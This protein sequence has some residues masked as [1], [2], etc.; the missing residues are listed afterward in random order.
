[1]LSYFK[2]SRFFLYII[3]FGVAI[4]S[5]STLFPF[6]VGKYVWFR[7]L[8]AIA[9]ILFLL[10]LLFDQQKRIYWERFKK[11]VRHPLF[12]VVG[13][14]VLAFVLACF[15]GVDPY[16]SFWSNFERGEGGFQ[17]LHMFAFFALLVALFRKKEYWQKFFLIFILAALLMIT[18]GMFS[19]LKYVDAELIAEEV[20]G[21]INFILSGRGGPLFQTFHNFLGPSFIDSGYRF[22]GSIGN[23]AYVAIYLI[24]STFFASYLLV[25]GWR[26]LETWKKLTFFGGIAIFL[27]YF[28]QAATRGAF[29]GLG[30]GVFAGLL[31]LGLSRKSWRKPA[32]GI[33]IFLILITGT[34]IHFKDTDFVKNIP[35]SR[36]FDI[37]LKAKTFQHRA[38]MWGIAWDGFLERPVF[39]WGPENYMRIFQEKYDPAYYTPSRGF[40]AWFDRAHSIIFDYLAETGVIG[41]LSY[42][43]IWVVYF[44]TL[45]KKR[46]LLTTHYPLLT[47]LFIALPIAYLVQGLALFDIST[48]YIPLFAFLGF[49][50]YK[51]ET[52]N[53]KENQHELV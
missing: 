18:Y 22:Q 21:N 4:V 19:E 52:L 40:G 8:V 32:I 11:I 13:I 10:G 5:R 1:M 31:Y 28:F 6:I 42:L 23:P 26:K 30:A 7:S 44:W 27:V 9:L 37:S 17:M 49:A 33:L 25:S 47:A 14:F 39:G 38:I 50:V 41:L 2:L 24:F 34:M 53:N 29:L 35:G 15:F 46:A 36:I 51:F 45:V 3:P 16:F 20:N 48:T 12:I 43:S